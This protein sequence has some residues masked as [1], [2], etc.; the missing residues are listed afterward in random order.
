V[1][2][3]SSLGLLEQPS[4]SG[5]AVVTNRSID[6]GLTWESAVTVKTGNGFLD[7]NWTACDNS[8]QS[9]YFGHCYTEWDDNGAG[10]QINMSTSTDGAKT[11]G[12]SATTADGATGLGG[13]PLVQPNG[14]VIV[15]IGDAMIGSIMA[16]KSTDGGN[17]WSATTTVSNVNA[18]DADGGLRAEPLPSAEIDGDG[19]VFVV[20]Q[21]C[22]FE[23]NCSSNDIVLTTS[24]D[25]STWSQIVRIPLDDVGSG[26]DHFIP[27]LGV[28]PE[29]HGDSAHLTVTY[30]YYENAVCGSNCQLN[31]ASS[32]SL[33]GGKTW[34]KPIRLAG[35]FALS[36][37]PLTSQGNMVG[38][39]ISTSYSLGKAY[40]VFANFDGTELA[41]HA[42]AALPI[43]S[44]GFR[45]VDR[46]PIVG[47][48]TA[49]LL[50]TPR[51][52]KLQ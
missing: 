18:H 46:P 2:V 21:D 35:P 34:S 11:W 47:H 25:G 48:G 40:S 38:D 10:N 49:R 31:V 37:T 3:I 4:V 45:P 15:P 41:M 27:G 22:R 16:F 24:T 7:K 30:Y 23:A 17:S 9:P 42:S 29:T 28:D 32:T 19:K 14:T 5:A 1:W 8:A 36:S 6:G 39:Y 52:L 26:V 43:G 13:Q 44:T 50:K 33:D 12:A 51:Y 20:W